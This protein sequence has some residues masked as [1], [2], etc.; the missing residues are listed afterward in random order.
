MTKL[1]AVLLL[2]SSACALPIEGDESPDSVE[3][4]TEA[5]APNVTCGWFRAYTVDR[6]APPC[7]SVLAA[8]TAAALFGE[9]TVTCPT[10]PNCQQ[11]I[12][13]TMP[14]GS[15]VRVTNRTPSRVPGGGQH[16]VGNVRFMNDNNSMDFDWNYTATTDLDVTKASGARYHAISQPFG[17]GS[18]WTTCVNYTGG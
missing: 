14:A 4:S 18:T 11:P 6:S 5:L 16:A 2:L 1:L 17:G 10:N 9:P 8:Q 15:Q 12:T 13:C 7:T 3:S